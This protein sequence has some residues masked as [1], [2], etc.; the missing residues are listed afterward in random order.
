MKKLRRLLHEYCTNF[1]GTSISE[2][3]D[4][5]ENDDGINNIPAY[6]YR[7]TTANGDRDID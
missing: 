3:V 1:F 6:Q 4:I 5:K 7:F 2:V